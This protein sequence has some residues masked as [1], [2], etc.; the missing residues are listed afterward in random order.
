MQSR[1]PVRVWI[2]L[3]VRRGLQVEHIIES[4]FWNKLITDCLVVVRIC[5]YFRWS[6]FDRRSISRQWKYKWWALV[7][8]Q[9]DDAH[10]RDF[11]SAVDQWMEHLFTDCRLQGIKIHVMNLH[12]TRYWRTNVQS[13][14][15]SEERHYG[16]VVTAQDRGRSSMYF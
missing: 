1:G 6:G 3:E 12:G 4:G 16:A 10:G 14:W 5:R 2:T 7:Q 9:L 13:M 11:R 8:Y 15:P